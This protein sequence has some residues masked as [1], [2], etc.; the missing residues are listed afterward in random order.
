MLK[1]HDG[2]QRK[3]PSKIK[4]ILSQKQINSILYS[5]PF[6]KAGFISKLVIETEEPILYVDL[7]LLYSG[8]AV[9]GILPRLDNLTLYQPTEDTIAQILT[10]VLVKASSSQV[11]VVVDSI[12]GLFNILNL[13]K[14]V[15]RS[16]ASILMLLASTASHTNSYLVVGSLV[17]YRKEEGWVLSPTGKRLIETKNSRKLLLEYGKGGITVNVLDGGAKMLLP[18]DVLPL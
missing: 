17:R 12:N 3:P 18:A 13:K 4:N 16:V 9:S 2:K 15:G 5:D 6:L 1:N 11:L 14:E 7:D 8:Y 10:D